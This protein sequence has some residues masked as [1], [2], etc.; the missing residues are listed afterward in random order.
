[1]VSFFIPP[2]EPK[3]LNANIVRRLWW[4]ERGWHQ[5][6]SFEGEIFRHATQNKTKQTHLCSVNKLMWRTDWTLLDLVTGQLYR[7][8]YIH[9]IFFLEKNTFFLPSGDSAI[10]AVGESSHPLMPYP[11][12]LPTLL[13]AMT[14]A[15]SP[16]Q[17]CSLYTII[18]HR[19]H[20]Q[21]WSI[22]PPL[23][24]ALQRYYFFFSFFLQSLG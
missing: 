19:R 16:P 2:G 12:L 13:T 10:D 9:L 4:K 14:T 6:E 24:I 17:H 3:R 5:R 7:G 21:Q 20:P 23:T 15:G 8:F 1:M 22:P 18:E 11:P